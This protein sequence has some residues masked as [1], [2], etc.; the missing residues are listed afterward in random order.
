MSSARLRAFERALTSVV[1]AA[2]V[3]ARAGVDLDLGADLDEQRHLD[4]VAG[5]DVR[6]LGARVAAV[7]LQARLGVRDL[8][9]DRGGQ[10]DVE[11]VAVV[12]GDG[13]RA[14]L[15]QE[16]GGVTDDGGRHVDLVVV[17]GVHEDE[18]VA[19]AVQVLEVAAVDV[20]DVDLR[21]GVV[22]LVDDLPGHDVL[23]LGADERAALARLDV[24][25]LDDVP[26]LAVDVE[27][28][29]VADVSGRGHGGPIRDADAAPETARNAPRSVLPPGR[30]PSGSP[31]SPVRARRGGGAGPPTARAD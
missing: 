9:D 7:A 25:E 17:R 11:R 23:Q 10:L 30:G 1:H 8:H 27:H 12:E 15:E 19:V 18:V 14:V 4:L 2:E 21:A 5:L 16:V 6:R 24:L 31:S 20:L 28:D 13:R 29:A 26:E 22:R 3:V